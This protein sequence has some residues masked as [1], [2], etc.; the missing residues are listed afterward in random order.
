M[1]VPHLAER[2]ELVNTIAL[3]FGEV[4]LWI[5]MVLMPCVS[6][7]LRRVSTDGLK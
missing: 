7:A 6:T 5:M 1:R 3:D 2:F 4:M